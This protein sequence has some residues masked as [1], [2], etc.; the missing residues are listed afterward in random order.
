MS[1]LLSL[2]FFASRLYFTC[3]AVP[4]NWFVVPEEFGSQFRPQR[5]LRRHHQ[6]MKMDPIGN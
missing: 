6:R 5:R 1:W 2:L 3:L 4:E